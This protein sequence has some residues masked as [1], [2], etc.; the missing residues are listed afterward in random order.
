MINEC[1]NLLGQLWGSI[2]GLSSSKEKMI[3]E[4][5]N[6]NCFHNMAAEEGQSENVL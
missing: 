3:N 4:E 2:L 5:T 1:T 6:D